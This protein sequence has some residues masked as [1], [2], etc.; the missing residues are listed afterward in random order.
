MAPPASAMLTGA[1][2]A[3]VAAAA[4]GTYPFI[5]DYAKYILVTTIF[6]SF[7]I[8]WKVRTKMHGVI[9]VSTLGSFNCI[10]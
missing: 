7:D 2:G 6:V 10:L 8:V 1:A 3:A 4:A 5:Q 9:L